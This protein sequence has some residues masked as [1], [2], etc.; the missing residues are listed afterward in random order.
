MKAKHLIGLA[1]TIIG[2]PLYIIGKFDIKLLHRVHLRWHSTGLVTV[3][4][5]LTFLGITSTKFSQ[6]II[7]SVVSESDPNVSVSNFS[8]ENISL[9]PLN[10]IEW[11]D[12]P[13]L[14]DVK[15]LRFRSASKELPVYFLSSYIPYEAITYNSYEDA[16]ARKTTDLGDMEWQYASYANLVNLLDK[17]VCKSFE[18]C[19]KQ[20]GSGTVLMY[21][22]SG[23]IFNTKYNYNLNR[24]IR[25]MENSSVP[26]IVGAGVQAFFATGKGKESLNDLNPDGI[27]SQT[28]E[29]YDLSS[30]TKHLLEILQKH[31]HPVFVRGN[32]TLRVTQLA[33]YSYGIATGCPSLMMSEKVHLGR[34]VQG[35]Y[36][37]LMEREGDFSLKVAININ[38]KPRLLETY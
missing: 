24:E 2:F 38:S 26:F 31:E 28:P 19:H 12:A 13:I 33:G 10:S 11:Y 18:K 23:D 35:K 37:A 32:F 14:K 21:G 36:S 6:S 34:V 22:P 16:L 9:L 4:V 15:N 27:I 17:N 3:I 30:D 1:I 20:N 5:F 25:L 29:M 8:T 7:Y